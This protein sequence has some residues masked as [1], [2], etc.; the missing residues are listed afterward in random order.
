[1]KINVI[2]TVEAAS[3]EEYI[4]GNIADMVKLGQLR[5]NMTK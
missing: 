3:I 5:V 1:M 2:C 4:C